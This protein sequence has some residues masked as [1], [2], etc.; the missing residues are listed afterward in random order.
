MSVISTV[1]VMPNR[2][3]LVHRF[4]R[5]H[6]DPLPEKTLLQLLSPPEIRKK[7]AAVPK[8]EEEKPGAVAPAVVRECKALGLIADAGG[9]QVCL[10]EDANMD[11]R[12]F[13]EQ[14]LLH[15]EEAERCRQANVPYALAWFLCQ[16]P[17]SPLLLRHNQKDRVE[18]DT[19]GKTLDLT[20]KDRFR[21]FGFWVRYLGLGWW[22]RGSGEER[23]VPDPTE[24]LLRHLP[25][26]LQGGEGPIQEVIAALGKRLP[27]LETGAVRE[28]VESWLPL[29]KRREPGDLS[30]ATSLAL[31]RLQRRGV[32][33]LESRSDAPMM[34]LMT[35]PNPTQVSHLVW[36]GTERGN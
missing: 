12:V 1:E 9:D 14:R 21:H 11:I 28:T 36:K 17:A 23:L 34:R 33:A 19:G 32:L 5:M 4:L 8:P 30:P 35:W 3:A 6:A 15:P 24:A 16:D 20:N 2:I 27:V 18:S 26:V 13:L 29:E 25:A 22:L 10:A 7:P 31:M